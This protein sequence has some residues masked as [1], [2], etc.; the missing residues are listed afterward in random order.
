M[1]AARIGLFGGAF[2]PPHAAHRALIEAALAQLRLDKLLVLPTGQ[3]WHKARALSPAQHRVAMAELAFAD[4]PR[5]QIDARET[6]RD[7]PTYTVD[8]LRELHRERPG[9]Q[10]FLI[11]GQDQ[12]QT[13]QQ[14]HA[15]EAVVQ[16]AKICVALRPALPGACARFDPPPGLEQ[17]FTTLQFEPT[18]LS[19]TAI[20]QQ[21][22]RAQRVVPL[23]CD[24]VARYIVLHHL[25]QNA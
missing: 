12:A 6:L 11:L 1:A 23:V 14:W 10:F 7:G 5:V 2:D 8:T 3:A 16:L 9:A 19:A 17:R 4:L 22:A 15:W 25:Y 13:L 20:R 24:R 18:A 21:F